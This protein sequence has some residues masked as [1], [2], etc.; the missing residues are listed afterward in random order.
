MCAP[1][2]RNRK[3]RFPGTN[4]VEWLYL[5]DECARDEQD[6]GCVWV[7]INSLCRTG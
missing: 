2:S 3:E 4:L 6:M 5:L 1:D 7:E